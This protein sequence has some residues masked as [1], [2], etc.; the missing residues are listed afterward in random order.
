[1]VSVKL[2]YLVVTVLCTSLSL[3]PSH[4]ELLKYT[5]ESH[6]DRPAVEAAVEA[7]RQVATHINEGK[8][9]LENIGRIG[10]WQES[11]DGWKV[12]KREGGDMADINLSPSICRVLI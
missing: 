5:S 11:I 2:K 7:M 8:R 3:S 10:K 4:Q 9:R 12:G 6:P 1:M